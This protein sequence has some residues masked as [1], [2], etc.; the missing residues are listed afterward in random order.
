MTVLDWT[1]CPVCG[2]VEDFQIWTDEQIYGSSTVWLDVDDTGMLKQVELVETE[3]GWNTAK[4]VGYFGSC[5]R[6]TLP[7]SYCAELDRVREAEEA[8]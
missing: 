7:D 2:N 3:I 4:V 5:C 8:E 6:E 1:R